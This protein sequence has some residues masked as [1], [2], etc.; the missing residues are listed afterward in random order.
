M[1]NKKMAVVGVGRYL[2]ANHKELRTKALTLIE[3]AMVLAIVAIFAL[4]ALRVVSTVT[5]GRLA[6]EASNQLN[7]IQQEVRSLYAG[8]SSFADLSPRTLVDTKAVPQSMISGSSL[9]HA[10]SGAIG[11]E[12]ASAAGGAN[13]GFRVTFENIPADVCVKMLTAD[14]GRGLYQAGVNSM[15]GQDGLPFTPTEAV[16]QCNSNYNNVSW[17]FY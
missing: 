3:T 2:K 5:Q 8:Q 10:F 16:G 17:V 14:L 9:R 11:L 7:I 1:R 13:S 15:V 12:P 4:G 6:T